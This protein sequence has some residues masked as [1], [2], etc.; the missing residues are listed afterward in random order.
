MLF[1]QKQ[2]RNARS[3]VLR[4]EADKW[5]GIWRAKDTH[6]VSMSC[7]VHDLWIPGDTWRQAS[8]SFRVGT[9]WGF[10]NLHV[11]QYKELSDEALGGL[12]WI[13]LLVERLGEFP[14]S[15][16]AVQVPLLEKKRGVGD[17]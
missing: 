4:A 15:M 9:A 10:D 6:P 1:S 13:A 7:E 16:R 11:S 14:G 12:S 2:A 5:S 17:L 8:G 3:A